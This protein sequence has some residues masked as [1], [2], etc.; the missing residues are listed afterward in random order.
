VLATFQ[1]SKFLRFVTRLNKG[2]LVIE[3]NNIIEKA[4]DLVRISYQVNAHPLQ[5]LYPG[6]QACG[7][8]WL[9]ACGVWRVDC[10][11]WLVACVLQDAAMA[12]ARSE[13]MKAGMVADFAQFQAAAGPSAADFAQFQA[14]QGPSAADFASFQATQG[15]SAAD[16][17]QFQAAQGPSAADFAQFQVSDPHR[18]HPVATGRPRFVQILLVAHGGPGHTRAIS[19]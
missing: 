8:L 9:V 7:G 3:G 18:A 16:F 6:T 5:L 2:E 11:V 15:P 17:A 10:G 19:G 1:N 13:Q 12:D 4:P 14:A